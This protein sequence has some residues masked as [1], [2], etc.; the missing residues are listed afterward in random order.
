MYLNKEKFKMVGWN[1]DEK[2]ELKSSFGKTEY[3]IIIRLQR[4]II[5]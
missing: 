1:E 3:V 2:F 4:N 5:L